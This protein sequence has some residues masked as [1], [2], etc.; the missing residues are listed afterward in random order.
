MRAPGPRTSHAF[1]VLLYFPSAPDEEL[2]GHDIEARFGLRRDSAAAYLAASVRNGLLERGKTADG[3]VYR[4][5]PRLLAMIAR[6]LQSDARLAYARMML[7]AQGALQQ[8]R[9]AQDLAEAMGVDTRDAQGWLVDL[10]RAGC[11]RRDPD[12]SKWMWCAG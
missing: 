7:A 10:Y 2:T 3:A 12:S 11:I 1:E 5:G 4:S 9:S 6:R 8:P